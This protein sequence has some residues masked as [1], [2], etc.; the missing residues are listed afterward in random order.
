MQ[1]EL[2]GQFLTDAEL[3]VTLIEVLETCNAYAAELAR[4]RA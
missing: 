2:V 4:L 1:R 3:K